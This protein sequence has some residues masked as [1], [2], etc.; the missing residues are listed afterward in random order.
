MNNQTQ[1]HAGV[2]C[3]TLVSTISTTETPSGQAEI[4]RSCCNTWNKD[5]KPG[6]LYPT[7]DRIEEIARDYEALMRAHRP[8]LTERMISRRLG[9][10]RSKVGTIPV[11]RTGGDM[12][13]GTIGAMKH[14]K[15][16]KIRQDKDTIK[17]HVWKNLSQRA[18]WRSANTGVGSKADGLCVFSAVFVEN[19]TSKKIDAAAIYWIDIDLD[20]KVD[21]LGKLLASV[22]K[23]QADLDDFIAW[24]HSMGACDGYT[25]ASHDPVSGR[26]HAKAHWP[27]EPIS[28]FER[29]IIGLE[30]R[31]MIGARYGI[32]PV[33]D[34][35]D[36][37][38]GKLLPTD[39]KCIDPIAERG[40]QLQ[41]LPRMKD[42][43][44][45]GLHQQ[46]PSTTG[47]VINLKALI[48]FARNQID[49]A[50][51]VKSE[52]AEKRK[53]LGLPSPEAQATE[54]AAR[55][56]L[57]EKQKR[58]ERMLKKHGPAVENCHGDDHT[59]QAILIG[60]KCGL[61]TEDFWPLL[62]DWNDTCIPPWD[63]GEL[64]AY[65][66][67]KY[68][69]APAT[70]VGCALPPLSERLSIMSVLEG[71]GGIVDLDLG[72]TGE[73][74]Q[75]FLLKDKEEKVG[76]LPLTAPV[77]PVVGG[78]L[79]IK[80]G[81]SIPRPAKVT[82]L[83]TPVLPA[84]SLEKL[85]HRVTIIDSACCTQKTRSMIPLFEE[86]KAK[87]LR[88]LGLV[89][90]Q[91]LSSSQGEVFGVVSH[92]DETGILHWENS[93]ISCFDSTWKVQTSTWSESFDMES[94]KVE[95]Q[96]PI[97]V[98]FVDEL[99][100]ISD[101]RTGKTLRD[102]H[103]CDLVQGKLE[104]MAQ[105]HN[106]RWVFQTAHV[107]LEAIMFVLNDIFGW[108][109]V[110][111][112]D[113][114]LIVNDKQVLTPDVF[115]G[116][117]PEKLNKEIVE[118]LMQN[119]KAICFTS[120]KLECEDTSR[121]VA[122][123]VMS[124]R[125]GFDVT[126]FCGEFGEAALDKADKLP[127]LVEELAKFGKKLE[128]VR[129]KIL[130][131]NADQM[132]LEA[133]AALKDPS[134]M[135]NYDF[136]CHTSSIRSGFN[137]D[138]E[139]AVFARLVEGAGPAAESNHQAVLRCRRPWNNRLRICITG[140]APVQSTDWK[141]HLKILMTRSENSDELLAGISGVRTATRKDGT[142]YLVVH[143]P[144]LVEA[145]AR[146][147]ARMERQ[148]H[149]ADRFDEMGKLVQA[150]AQAK[151]WQG[152]GWNVI[153]LHEMEEQAIWAVPIEEQKVKGKIR[154]KSR[155]AIKKVS[156]RKIAVA[157]GMDKETADKMKKK[158]RLPEV[159]RQVMNT[160]VRW[161]YNLENI[162][163]E[164]VEW[165]HK[166]WGQVVENAVRVAYKKS[167]AKVINT[168]ADKDGPIE[169][170][171]RHAAMR[172]E[173]ANRWLD[174]L[175]L[176]DLEAFA[177]SGK[178]LP[179]L[180]DYLIANPAEMAACA[181]HF[182]Y[183]LWGCDLEGT[184]FTRKFLKRFGIESNRKQF[185]INGERVWLHILKAESVAQMNVKSEASVLRLLDEEEAA[186]QWLEVEK[187]TVSKAMGV[188]PT[189]D[190]KELLAGI[191]AQEAST[192]FLKIV[193]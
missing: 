77:I 122:I 90:S 136:I 160:T 65:M 103:R 164:D 59:F 185:P 8:A 72:E 161:R 131:V 74:H 35:F 98:V 127:E 89:P 66:E 141:D 30:I 57:D 49:G 60:I 75:L 157:T 102:A 12:V 107:D 149:I 128:D 83:S 34:K 146:R 159:R 179:S 55:T 42:L 105:D 53:L 22:L 135:G 99:N 76:A 117:D 176:G 147:R 112:A 132:S 156:H 25:T 56:N 70:M 85:V 27:C 15:G 143:N 177:A 115:I 172:A 6:L 109:D 116:H 166:H 26:F 126:P 87:G 173:L 91:S 175:G 153:F 133:Q 162:T 47:P 137:I 118:V 37:K 124:R 5:P 40:V 69:K 82:M 138:A 92:M 183:R 3:D 51:K 19:K 97:A 150:G 11:V 121:Q 180:G 189:Q 45:L 62:S 28:Y 54:R 81:G 39:W 4:V 1:A 58:A 144:M 23:T 174:A 41:H 158:S 43:R 36:K 71:K 32:V 86:C 17:V 168:L 187:I 186:K 193:A 94:E 125:A 44:R 114:E 123:G 154:K 120:T 192:T 10:M 13:F 31:K 46:F 119:V 29:A 113:Y 129:P 38:T 182:E 68:A 2:P 139:R 165:D 48:R 80:G 106:T 104:E 67:R 169:V 155:S 178:P 16:G 151:F 171:Q 134:L 7:D 52:E 108:T 163:A 110:D 111:Q 190:I 101:L 191:L 152:L 64:Q 14:G 79:L 20:S 18:E 95:T 93:I 140:S 184:N 63:E 100:E 78:R 84:Q 170:C 33:A 24:C 188:G 9:E 61:S 145:E 130:Q 142:K 21:P 88:V 148:A 50:V 96:H 167:K 73:V 181:A